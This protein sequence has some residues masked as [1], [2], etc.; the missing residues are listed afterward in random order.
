MSNYVGKMNSEEQIRLLFER[1]ESDDNKYCTLDS[2]ETPAP[3][4]RSLTNTIS[5]ESESIRSRD[6]SL[7]ASASQRKQELLDLYLA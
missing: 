2:K 1:K 4:V 3:S 5:S 6:S 7:P